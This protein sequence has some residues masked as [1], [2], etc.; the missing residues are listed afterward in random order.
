[1]R[2]T[3]AK[4]T[5]EDATTLRH[6]LNQ[7]ALDN[8]QLLKE[9]ERQQSELEQLKQGNYKDMCGH[10][11]MVRQDVMKFMFTAQTSTKCRAVGQLSFKQWT[12]ITHHLM[13]EWEPPEHPWDT[14]KWIPRVIGRTDVPFP[15]PKHK[16]AIVGYQ[17]Q[18]AAKFRHI[19]H[20]DGKCS[21]IDFRHAMVIA[22]GD[23]E[24]SLLENCTKEYRSR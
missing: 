15:V 8:R 1:M 20:P 10:A 19:T 5:K 16:S 24:L 4:K 13:C 7:L 21:T 2:S 17:S 9:N 23:V 14:G 18:I 6:Q 22:L 3:A 12:Y 11:R